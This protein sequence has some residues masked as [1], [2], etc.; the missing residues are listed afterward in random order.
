[1]HESEKWKLSHSVV[2]DSSDP[3]DCSLPGSCIH[4]IFQARVLE[5]GAIAFSKI[6]IRHIKCQSLSEINEYRQTLWKQL[7]KISFL[8]T[9]AFW[10]CLKRVR[11]QS[12]TEICKENNFREIFSKEHHL[13]FLQSKHLLKTYYYNYYPAHLLGELN[14]KG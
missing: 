13:F 8:H 5:W 14:N 4:G 3:M 2:S 9:Y 10:K 7:L 11:V 6:P 12:K 1:M